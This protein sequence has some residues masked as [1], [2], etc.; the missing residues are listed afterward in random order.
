MSPVRHCGVRPL[1]T[2]QRAGLRGYRRARTRPAAADRARVRLARTS[3]AGRRRRGT[4]PIRTRRH[5]AVGA[6]NAGHLRDSLRRLGHEMYDELRERQVK[7]PA[8]E[9]Q[10][11]DDTAAHVDAGSRSRTADTNDSDGSIAV[12]AAEPSRATSSSVSAPGPQPT[13][14]AVCPR[15]APTR[16]AK[17]GSKR[18]REA[19]HE[20]VVRRRGNLEAHLNDA[21]P[22]APGDRGS[23]ATRSG[24][25]ASRRSGEG[26]RPRRGERRPAR[27]RR[28]PQQRRRAHAR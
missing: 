16:S 17:Q 13:S 27:R 15:R 19:A 8:R 23:P 2:A 28:V 21:S 20:P 1:E 5:N 3:R 10:I 24:W 6:G 4:G 9:R 14:S 26:R 25:L 11:L 12:T 7:T 22:A 18:H